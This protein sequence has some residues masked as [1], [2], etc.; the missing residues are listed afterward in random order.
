MN[1]DE[2]K[3]LEALARACDRVADDHK[4]HDC[5]TTPILRAVSGAVRHAVRDSGHK[6]PAQVATDAYRENWQTLFGKKA[7]VGQ[8]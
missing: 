5:D 1:D 2:K 4:T 6:G 7:P 8:A 3:R